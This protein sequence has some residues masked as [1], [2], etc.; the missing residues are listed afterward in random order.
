MK[1]SFMDA[2]SNID[3]NDKGLKIIVTLIFAIALIG[4]ISLIIFNFI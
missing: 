1:I 2:N 4:A 3:P